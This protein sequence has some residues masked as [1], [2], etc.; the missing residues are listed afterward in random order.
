MR[1][2]EEAKNSSFSLRLEAGQSIKYGKM[3]DT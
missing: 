2:P 3:L 1:L